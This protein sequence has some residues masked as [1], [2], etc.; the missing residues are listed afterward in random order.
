MPNKS[1]RDMSVWEKLHYSLSSRMFRT[2]MMFSI[3]LASVA[4]LF[5]FLLYNQTIVGEYRA[6]AVN[7]ARTVSTV[8][9]EESWIS[10]ADEVLEIYED[11]D[12]KIAE[13]P[14][15]EAYRLR[16]ASI[17]DGVYDDMTRYLKTLQEENGASFV[18]L[19]AYDKTEDRLVY[20]FDSDDSERNCY[21][22]DWQKVNP[23]ETKLYHTDTA[24]FIEKTERYGNL[25]TG[26][27]V[28]YETDRF[29]LMCFSDFSMEGVA[30]IIRTYLWQYFLLMLAVTLL[31]DYL[32]VRRV[33]KTVIT[34]INTLTN[35]AEEYRIDKIEGNEAKRHFYDLGISTG[36]EIE[37]LALIME[38]ME[39]DISDYVETVMA[40]TTEKERIGT[41]LHIASEIQDG[42]LPTTFPAFPDRNEFDIYAT[43]HPAR[44]IGG[45]FY[46]YFLLD[47]DH[48]ALTIADVSGK[49]VPGAL[50]MMSSKILI[51]ATAPQY[52]D[53]P[54]SILAAVNNTICHNNN[55]EMF[56]TAWLGILEIS[57]GR[58]I[59][60]NAGHENPLFQ[61]NGK[62][63][64]VFRDKHGF[65][66]GGLENMK[67]TN[68]ELQLE[69]GDAV[70]LYTDGVTEASDS[71]RN[72][73]G[74][75]RLMEAINSDPFST[76]ERVLRT[77]KAKIDEFA[78]EAEQFDDITMLM[79]RYLGKN[80]DAVITVAAE[81][82][83]V[84]LVTEFIEKKLA[85]LS[86]GLKTQTQID[87]AVD[88]IFSNIANYA[89]PEEK[90]N[91]TIRV[92]TDK[93]NNEITITFI[94]EG[95][96]YDP[97]Q[98]EAP[99]T[100]LS[101]DKRDIGGLGIFLIRKTMDEV[102][103][104]YQDGKNIL[105][106]RKKTGGDHGTL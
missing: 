74:E 105:T 58:L 18:Y 57:S 47:D 34:P 54:A 73:F 49:G 81:V 93:L 4:I 35:A 27:D 21:P 66:L 82:K 106:I 103:Y 53:D 10:V 20:V 65:V 79:L 12:P 64:E 83:N 52:P 26:W 8:L 76:P 60:A 45:D 72:L 36:D 104:D 22:G 9:K 28:I 25:C 101:A 33:K 102:L 2:I 56:V 97:L 31:L 68:Y 42:M 1:Y 7:L 19:A 77:V 99:D 11:T 40:V 91:V 44:E 43:M 16:F 98:A 39:G 61:K 88:E 30:R 23:R 29:I 48:L 71:A 80:D 38:D 78:D 3:A 92:R 75:E 86:C 89:Y 96:P 85:S 41:E 50:F 84:S 46:D 13:D 15:S 59:A 55:V 95:M 32:I 63:F 37:K 69:P 6:K 5:G 70:F 100:T 17:K 51:N 90:G 24:S 62:R 87:I 14:S 94:D 67:Y